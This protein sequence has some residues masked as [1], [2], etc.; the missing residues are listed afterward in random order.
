L[1][2]GYL[3]LCHIIAARSNGGVVAIVVVI[4]ILGNLIVPDF[5][6]HNCELRDRRLSKIL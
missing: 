3:L 1:F 6:A 2:L 4:A 5:A